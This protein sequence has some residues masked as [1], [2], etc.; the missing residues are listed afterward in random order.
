MPGSSQIGSTK[1]KTPGTDAVTKRAQS[2]AN[3]VWLGSPWEFKQRGESGLWVS[4]LFP[5]LAGVAKSH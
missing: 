5:H 1:P 2:N 4:D 3:R